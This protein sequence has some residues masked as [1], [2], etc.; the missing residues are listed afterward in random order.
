[1]I[2]KFNINNGPAWAV[3]INNG[4]NFIFIS[5]PVFGTEFFNL[6]FCHTFSVQN[7]SPVL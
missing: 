2:L 4:F 1:M 6:L 7:L 3:R 5:E